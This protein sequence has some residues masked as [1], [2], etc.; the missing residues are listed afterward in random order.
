MKLPE[1]GEWFTA[2]NKKWKWEVQLRHS[3]TGSYEKKCL[4]LLYGETKFVAEFK[5]LEELNQFVLR[6][7]K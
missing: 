1:E 6:I 2:K 4:T 3:F 7:L 5:T